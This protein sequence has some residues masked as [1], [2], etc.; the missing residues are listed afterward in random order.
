MYLYQSEISRETQRVGN[1][2]DRWED[3]DRYI[4]RQIDRQIDDKDR[5]DR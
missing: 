1:Q 2:I 4:D 5:L 3:K